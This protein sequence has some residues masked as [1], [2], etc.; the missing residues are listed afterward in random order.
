LIALLKCFKCGAVW[1]GEAKISFRAVCESCGT[2]LHCCKNC[3][4]FDEYA[5]NKCRIPG[6]EMVQDRELNNYCD[7]F[8]FAIK[9]ADPFAAKRQDDAKKKLDDLFKKK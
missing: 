7:E 8:E 4:F 9:K 1:K 2:G 3:K 6:T 5:H